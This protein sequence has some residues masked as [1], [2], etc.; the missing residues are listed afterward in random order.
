MMDFAMFHLMFHT[1]RV[2]VTYTEHTPK[3]LVSPTLETTS[4]ACPRFSPKCLFC[5][6]PNSSSCDEFSEGLQIVL[7]TLGMSLL[8]SATPP[9]TY[10]ACRVSW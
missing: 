1:I 7:F 5:E 4:P 3:C 6:M 2:Q 8:P 10:D 9:Q